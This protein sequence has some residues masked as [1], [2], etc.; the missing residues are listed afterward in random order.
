MGVL[1]ARHRRNRQEERE[2]MK[3]EEAKREKKKKKKKDE[4]EKDRGWPLPIEPLIY[5]GSIFQRKDGERGLDGGI[6]RVKRCSLAGHVPATALTPCTRNGR[7][8][9]PR[10]EI[11]CR[12]LVNRARTR[13]PETYDPVYFRSYT[14][15]RCSLAAIDNTTLNYGPGR[16]TSSRFSIVH[17]LPRAPRTPPRERV[18]KGGGRICRVACRA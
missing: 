14:C 13:P 2:R 4:K 11:A 5:G 17:E 12:N 3:A 7:S 8:R 16:N 6:A 15:Y 9:G 18:Y 10:D 1:V